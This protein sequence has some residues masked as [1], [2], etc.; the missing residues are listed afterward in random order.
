LTYKVVSTH[1]T[2]SFFRRALF[3]KN[4][5]MTRKNSKRKNTRSR[6]LVTIARQQGLPAALQ[7]LKECPNGPKGK[8]WREEKDGIT[9]IGLIAASQDPRSIE[10]MAERLL[11]GN[12]PDAGTL[13]ELA[14]LDGPL[15]TAKRAMLTIAQR[16]EQAQ[17]GTLGINELVDGVAPLHNLASLNRETHPV[18]W[19]NFFEKLV[20]LKADPWKKT[21]EG[22]DAF[23]L[24]REHSPGNIVWLYVAGCI[25]RPSLVNNI[26]T[27]GGKSTALHKLAALKEPVPAAIRRILALGANPVAIDSKGRTAFALAWEQGVRENIRTL[28]VPTLIATTKQGAKTVAIT[29]ALTE[30]TIQLMTL[31]RMESPREA[32]DHFTHTPMFLMPSFLPMDVPVYPAVFGVALATTAGNGQEALRRAAESWVMRN[33]V[34]AGGKLGG[35]DG[36]A[37]AAH[38]AFYLARNPS[39]LLENTYLLPHIARFMA[40]INVSDT[41]AKHIA[42]DVQELALRCGYRLP[43][44]VSR[45]LEQ[46]ITTYVLLCQSRYLPSTPALCGYLSANPALAAAAMAAGGIAQT[47]QTGRRPPVSTM[48]VGAMTATYALGLVM[49]V[50]K[51]VEDMMQPDIFPPPYQ[52]PLLP[53]EANYP[54]T[55]FVNGTILFYAAKTAVSTA[56]SVTRGAVRAIGDAKKQWWDDPAVPPHR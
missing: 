4:I 50:Y 36:R 10:W 33:I 24:A 55:D 42:L 37:L 3:F 51:G 15:V 43:P 47:L 34:H 13:E 39:I 18:L 16:L 49:A 19:D 41:L 29:A 35:S 52:C 23:A 54:L 12:K 9:L 48:L 38:L 1:I 11:A 14:R 53:V 2:L 56:V 17:I 28:I 21:G 44:S 32:A 7:R 40:G 26:D 46:A 45:V 30:L 5:F 8:S 25:L 31:S 27:A 22:R 6:N 20:T